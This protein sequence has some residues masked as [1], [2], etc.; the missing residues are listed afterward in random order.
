MV[1]ITIRSNL[2][3]D[4]RSCMIF[5]SCPSLW[6]GEGELK[7]PTQCLS[8]P[9]KLEDPAEQRVEGGRAPA[10]G[11]WRRWMLVLLPLFPFTAAIA[12]TLHYLTCE[13][14][15]T[16]VLSLKMC[17][18]FTYTFKSHSAPVSDLFLL[19]LLSSAL[20]SVLPRRQ[21]GVLKPELLFRAD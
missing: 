18:F 5:E 12:L 11:S 16:L 4:I 10:C 15:S 7:E 9:T 2:S 17:L 3:T 14:R 19:L 21:R 1:I 20:L 6:K 8:S 13:C